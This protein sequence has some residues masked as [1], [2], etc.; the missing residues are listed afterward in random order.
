[1]S[2]LP[3]ACSFPLSI[4]T[5]S[6]LMRVAPESECRRLPVRRGAFTLIELLVVIAIIAILAALLLPALA[7]S[8]QQALGVKCMS[9]CKQLLLGW[10]LYASE[11]QEVLP[12]N[13]SDPEAIGGWCQGWL[14][15]TSKNPDNTNYVFMM[16]GA[17]PSDDA[18]AQTGTIGG[19]VK[20]PGVYQCPA[21]PVL[22]LG[23]GMPRC[24][25]YS[26]DFT[27]GSKST[28]AQTG[29]SYVL[30]PDFFKMTDFKMP[31][32]TWVFSDEHPDSI[33]GGIQYIPS[34]VGNN[35]D[36][37]HLPAAYH[38]GTC[39]FAFADDHA[40]MHKWM[41][42]NTLHAITGNRNWLPFPVVGS[43]VDINWVLSHASPQLVGEPDQVP[44]Q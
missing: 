6:L 44:G 31:S 32:K 3:F 39:D 41:N 10:T 18:P 1:M 30:W 15:E 14:T 38:N 11:N 35:A 33:E 13:I 23:Y 16:G 34:A 43:Q 26:M 24:R 2:P 29:S 17:S 9:N 8:K 7:R 21:D 5:E 22:A 19:Y 37:A 42:P 28:N 40:E 25:S 4:R 12:N 36:W 27:I 20:N